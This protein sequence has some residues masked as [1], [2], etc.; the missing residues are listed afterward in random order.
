MSVMSRRDFLVRSA[1]VSAGII[2]TGNLASCTTSSINSSCRATKKGF[3]HRGF[4]GST[5]YFAEP[6]HGYDW[7]KRLVDEMVKN[8][9]NTLGVLCESISG[10]DPRGFGLGWPC[11][12]PGAHRDLNCINANPKKEYLSRIIEDCKSAQIQFML[13]IC[14]LDDWAF[15]AAHPELRQEIG[16]GK[17]D[18]HLCPNKPAAIQYI[19]SKV[20]DLVTFYPRADAIIL[21]QHVKYRYC[22]CPHC[23][24]DFIKTMGI[25]PA[26]ATDSELLVYRYKVMVRLTRGLLEAIKIKVPKMRAGSTLEGVSTEMMPER[27]KYYSQ[28]DTGLD[29]IFF[30]NLNRNRDNMN[31][32]TQCVTSVYDEVWVSC[33]VYTKKVLTYSDYFRGAGWWR[34]AEPSDADIYVDMAI[35]AYEQLSKPERFVGFTFWNI[36]LHNEKD[37]MREAAMR[38]IKRLA[39]YQP[40]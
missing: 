13:E 2:T 8:N 6:S 5:N 9:A 14:T 21:V 40:C 15:V 17:Y 10:P 26:K 31:G 16:D 24:S 36:S 29:F 38:A 39:T 25:E 12:V 27:K 11:A 32:V 20:V 33:G 1:E 4:I 34:P 23:R 37:P 35:D 28:A 30:Q 3:Q 19:R 22:K 7:W 18:R